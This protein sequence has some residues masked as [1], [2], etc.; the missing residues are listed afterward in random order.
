M[1]AIPFPFD[2]QKDAAGIR[3]EVVELLCDSAKRKAQPEFLDMIFTCHPHFI[4][5]LNLAT[6][7][8]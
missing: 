2:V 4:G 3:D 5:T 1:S 7:I 6:K 8:L